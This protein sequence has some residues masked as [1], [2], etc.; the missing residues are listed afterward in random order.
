MNTFKL[1]LRILLLPFTA[2]ICGS[3]GII[4]TFIALMMLLISFIEWLSMDD[5][6]NTL[7]LALY[8]FSSPFATIYQFTINGKL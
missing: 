8:V 5:P 4:T 3:I 2:S 1:I 6:T 7:K